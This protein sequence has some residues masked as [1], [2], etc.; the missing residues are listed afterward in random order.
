MYMRRAWPSGKPCKEPSQH[1]D[2]FNLPATRYICNLSCT[3]T[4]QDLFAKLWQG[5]NP[6]LVS[7]HGFS[8]AIDIVSTQWQPYPYSRDLPEAKFNILIL[9]NNWKDPQR[10]QQTAPVFQVLSLDV[11]FTTSQVSFFGGGR[12]R[13]GVWLQSPNAILLFW[14]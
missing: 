1:K 6:S 7:F 10:W 13:R 9:A 3:E 8:S 5:S 11:L 2:Y 4:L 14:S 12:V